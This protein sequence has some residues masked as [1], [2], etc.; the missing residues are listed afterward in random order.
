[1][2]PA[3]KYHVKFFTRNGLILILSI[4][5]G[6]IV[7][8]LYYA[9]TLLFPIG[10]SINLAP[11]LIGLIVTLIQVGYVIGLLFIVPL[12]DFTE[13]RRLIVTLLSLSCLF[14]FGLAFIKAKV[15]FLILCF[16]L[17]ISL[18][19]SPIILPFIS[20][21]LPAEEHGMALGKIMSGVLFGIMF[22]RPLASGFAEFF[23]WRGVFIFSAVFMAA[24]ACLLYYFLPLRVPKHQMSYRKLLSSM[25][26]ILWAYPLLRRRAL[27]HAILFGL[28][29]LFWSSV[30]MQ[31]SHVFHYSQGQIA[32]FAF[33]GA[34]GGFTSPIAGRIADKG[35]IRPGTAG[36]II[37]VI[38]AFVVARIDGGHSIFALIISAL[39][40][41]IGVASN[42]VLGQK[43]LFSLK[44]E[45]RGRLNSLY[46]AIFFMGGAVGPAMAGYVFSHW[47]WSCIASLGVIT[48][49]TVF[50]Y[51]LSELF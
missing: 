38:V 10:A 26:T 6:A 19:A 37:V 28:F 32:L 50:I 8:N 9:Q 5:C 34:T 15:V 17:G 12:V 30:A 31:L 18:V 42:V 2:S 36:A 49:T 13:N 1:M 24:L 48:S 46:I 21:I 16:L 20:Y 35:W 43:A 11:S 39:L 22:A 3:T 33:A 25:P 7:A 14:L 29:C 45:I 4:A 40:L 51:F 47:G 27:Y 44:Q 23:S 41:D